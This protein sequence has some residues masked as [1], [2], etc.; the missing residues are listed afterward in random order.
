MAKPLSV[1]RANLEADRQM[2][3]LAAASAPALPQAAALEPDEPDEQPQDEQP[4]DEQPQYAPQQHAPQEPQQEQEQP[5]PQDGSDGYEHRFRVLQ[6]KY[7]AETRRLR[8]DNASLNA[9]LANMETLM[10][11]LA[12]QP[13]PAPAP[14]PAP[15]VERE[16]LPAFNPV[17]DREMEEYGADMLDAA[18][19]FTLV[20]LMPLIKNLTGEV[21]ELRG[22]VTT[23]AAQS[24]SAAQTITMNARDTMLTILD[25]KVPD[26]RTINVDDGFK[27]WLA[28]E[29]AMSGQ[30]RHSLLLHAYERNEG[31]RVLRFFHAYKAEQAAG[32]EPAEGRQGQPANRAQRVNPDALA[33]PGRGRSVGTPST[34]QPKIEWTPAGIQAFYNDVRQGVFKTNPTE[35]DRLERDIFAAQTEG[36]IQ[37]Y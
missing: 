33:A 16:E 18:S 1:L 31:P 13:A 6:G 2:A 11:Q 14:A 17:T 12:A 37:A 23:A 10:T 29:D 36:R 9:R 25:E 3:A 28:Q 5:Q 22:K 20:K 19:R 8:D 27:S 7:N 15:V 26:W 35:R 34:P 32:S 21:T 24:A 30:T 4:Q